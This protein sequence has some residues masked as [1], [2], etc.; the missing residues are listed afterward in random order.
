[1]SEKQ[2]IDNKFQFYDEKK[3]CFQKGISGI[4]QILLMTNW[5]LTSMLGWLVAWSTRV[6]DTVLAMMFLQI[7]ST[8]CEKVLLQILVM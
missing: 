7:R 3:N 6:S 1:M 5:E 4:N 8:W 2:M